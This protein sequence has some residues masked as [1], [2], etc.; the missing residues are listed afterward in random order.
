[1]D[2]GDW[3]VG[4]YENEQIVGRRDVRAKA[5]SWD[6]EWESR[7]MIAKGR[8]F[9]NHFLNN[10]FITNILARFSASKNFNEKS[11]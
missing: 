3:M 4:W 6:D 7:K 5:L 8:F 2:V 9:C 1:M 10:S 11:S